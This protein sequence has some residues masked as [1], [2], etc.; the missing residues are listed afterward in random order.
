[1]FG[2]EAGVLVLLFFLP[3]DTVPIIDFLDLGGIA[4]GLIWGFIGGHSLFLRLCSICLPQLSTKC[5]CC[6]DLTSVFCII[7]YILN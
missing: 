1:M 4:F 7:T 6:L 2:V 3:L 5:L